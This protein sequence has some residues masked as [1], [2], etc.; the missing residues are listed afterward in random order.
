MRNM[1]KIVG[2]WAHQFRLK[3]DYVVLGLAVGSGALIMGQ[4]CITTGQCATC[5]ACVSRLPILAFPLLA[6]ASVVLIGKARNHLRR[7]RERTVQS[8][9]DD[10]QV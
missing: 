1:L 6:Q 3:I 5:R 7:R 4:G 2:E 8:L 10:H 9:P